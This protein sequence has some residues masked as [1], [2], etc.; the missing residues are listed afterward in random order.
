MKTKKLNALEVRELVGELVDYLYHDEEADFE[1]YFEDE[2]E[3]KDYLSGKK[4]IPDAPKK[5]IFIAVKKL[6][7]WLGVDRE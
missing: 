5:H 3:A 2:D 6:N 7:D 4:K 1:S